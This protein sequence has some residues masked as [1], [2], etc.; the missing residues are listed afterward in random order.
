MYMETQMSC[1][2]HGFIPKVLPSALVV[3][4]CQHFKG[5]KDALIYI[6]PY[7]LGGSQFLVVTKF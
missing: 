4:V 2:T 6:L 3:D 1:E 5:C 7:D